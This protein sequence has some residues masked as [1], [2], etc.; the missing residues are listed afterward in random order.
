[1]LWDPDRY[2]SFSTPRS[3][4]AYDLLRSCDHP[5][6]NTV[7]DLGCGTGQITVGL[8]EKWPSARVF[9]L[10]SSAEMLDRAPRDHERTTWVQAD[11]REWQPESEVDVIFSNAAL[12][13]VDEHE[14]LFP[15]LIE[16][17]SP[18]GV[19]AVQMPANYDQP[20]H[21]IAIEMATGT[22][23]ESRLRHL[24]RPLP[25][26]S[27]GAYARILAPLVSD[28]N[29]WHST[30]LHVLDGDSAVSRWVEGSL[31]RPF[32]DAL[33]LDESAAFISEYRA[34]VATQ[35]EVLS[36]GRTLFPFRRLFVVGNRS[37]DA[38]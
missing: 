10:D 23:W 12:H 5:A 35:Y 25:V 29:I 24:A 11:V 1:M 37:V 7:V 8:A 22:R 2:G 32:L 15:R 16:Y 34:A 19:L 26:M 36:D 18:S 31:L 17:L 27:A 14:T 38:R 4:P 28:L 20:S 13:W 21:R 30:Y 9:G 3:R 33:D 6:P